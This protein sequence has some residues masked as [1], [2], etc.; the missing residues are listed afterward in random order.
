MK[1]FSVAVV[2]DSIKA[3]L[4]TCRHCCSDYT[5]PHL[6]AGGNILKCVPFLAD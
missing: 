2:R 3:V 5:V 6:T 4:T 1:T